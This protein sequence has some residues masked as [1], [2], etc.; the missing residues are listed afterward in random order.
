MNRFGVSPL[1]KFRSDF[2]LRFAD[3]IVIA[4]DFLNPGKLAPCNDLLCRINNNKFTAV[5]VCISLVLHVPNFALSD[6]HKVVPVMG[7]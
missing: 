2:I 4:T 6:D 7:R 1:R 3:V 5:I